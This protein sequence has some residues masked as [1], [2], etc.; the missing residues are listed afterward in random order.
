MAI[1]RLSR[2]GLPP[3]IARIGV[4]VAAFLLLSF[5]G[6][7][8]AAPVSL[9]FLFITSRGVDIGRPTK[10]VASI[11][12]AL[13]A[14]EVAWALVYVTLGES[15]PLIWIAPVVVGVACLVLLVRAIR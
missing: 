6:A 11:V 4:A 9:P 8:F 13:T 1:A 15:T 3:T 14:A 5:G 2:A 12:F 7:I 10:V